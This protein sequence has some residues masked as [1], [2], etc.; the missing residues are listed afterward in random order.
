MLIRY[1]KSN[2]K[3]NVLNDFLATFFFSYLR[4]KVFLVEKYNHQFANWCY[5]AARRRIASGKIV[6]TIIYDN[7]NT[8]EGERCEMII[9]TLTILNICDDIES[10][11][12]WIADQENKRLVRVQM[13]EGMKSALIEVAE[14]KQEVIRIINKIVRTK[15]IYNP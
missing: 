15:S 2:D 8:L 3:D 1:E 13:I 6:P 9:D 7:L 5:L 10:K 14:N 4:K 12:E 11:T